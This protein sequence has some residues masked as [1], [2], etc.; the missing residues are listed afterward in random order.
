M[1]SRYK[2]VHGSTGPL[3][4][5]SPRLASSNQSCLVRNDRRQT[6]CMLTGTIP[7]TSTWINPPT[8]LRP[9]EGLWACD[10]CVDGPASKAWTITSNEHAPEFFFWERWQ[11]PCC[12]SEDPS[13]NTPPPPPTK[14]ARL[15]N[16]NQLS[17]N[18]RKIIG[19]QLVQLQEQLHSEDAGPSLDIV[20]AIQQISRDMH[21][22]TF[23]LRP[24]K[25]VATQLITVRAGQV[26]DAGGGSAVAV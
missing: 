12:S 23:Y 2:A 9:F 19:K 3:H 18:Y 21:M 20:R 14:T 17:E 1:V 22:I 16:T 24:M 26:T 5:A 25:V 15:V 6:Q 11:P 13:P 10:V 8:L 4:L 7:P